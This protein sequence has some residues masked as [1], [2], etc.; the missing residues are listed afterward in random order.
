M[1]RANT[2]FGKVAIAPVELVPKIGDV[3]VREA[4]LA[5]PVKADVGHDPPSWRLCAFVRVRQVR[6]TDAG[7][8]QARP[9]A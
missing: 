3:L 4:G 7:R 8:P 2:F 5:Q 6:G 1:L 9:S